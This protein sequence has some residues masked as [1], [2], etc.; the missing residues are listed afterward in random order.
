VE[1]EITPLFKALFPQQQM[2]PSLV[3]KISRFG[4]VWAIRHLLIVRS[5]SFCAYFIVTIAP[6]RSPKVVLPLLPLL[7]NC[8]FFRFYKGCRRSSSPSALAWWPS[9][10]FLVVRG[11]NRLVRIVRYTRLSCHGNQVR[12]RDNHLRVGSAGFVTS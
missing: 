6:G 12:F 2:R 7:V 3:H 10:W 1:R 8:G 9:T 4:S 11:D 5:S